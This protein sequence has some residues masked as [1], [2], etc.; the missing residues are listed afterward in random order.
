V[1][2][3][4][5]AATGRVLRSYPAAPFGGAVAASAHATVVV[6]P[7]A[8]T[9]YDNATGR[10]IWSR[11]IGPAAQAWRSD[12]G[13][14]F[15]AEASGG[16]L[17]NGAAAKLLRISLRTGAEQ[18]IKPQAGAF[19]GRLA[20]V[21]RG[22]ALFSGGDGVNAYSVATGRLLWRRAG[23]VPQ[24]LDVVRGLFYLNIGDAV[25]GVHPGT[26]RTATR[27]AGADGSGSAGVYGV[28]ANVALGLDLGPS[29]DAWGYDVESQRVIWT[30]RTLP[31]PH[32][33]IDLSGI[34]GSTGPRSDTLLLAICL[35]RTVTSAGPVCQD[36]ELAL[37]SR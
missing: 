12:G 37:I 27:V 11:A 29:G 34:G 2:V 5:S 19:D 23:A 21:L 7:A 32:Y 36:P 24:S 9:S 33:F 30:T 17:G 25:T 10:R 18:V 8:V 14:L 15:V 20:A 16:S 6:G 31:W 4:L 26:G 3:V 35:Q 1:T 22:V 13:H 28:R